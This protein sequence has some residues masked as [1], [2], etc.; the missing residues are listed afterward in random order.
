M[1]WRSGTGIDWSPSCY[2]CRSLSD[3]LGYSEIILMLMIILTSDDL[4]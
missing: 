3:D 4:F 1:S 2:A